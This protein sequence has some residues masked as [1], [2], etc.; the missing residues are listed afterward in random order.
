MVP[1]RLHGVPGRTGLGDESL[2]QDQQRSPTVGNAG[3]DAKGGSVTRRP[4][5][6]G[7]SPGHEGRR[8]DSAG[9]RGLIERGRRA[10]SRPLR[11]DGVTGRVPGQP[12]AC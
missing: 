11:Q 10:S 1:E 3:Q 9:S 8:Q 7:V 5:Q 12:R 6:P 2:L 4:G